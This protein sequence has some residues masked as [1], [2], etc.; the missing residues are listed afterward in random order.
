MTVTRS[1]TVTLTVTLTVL[2]GDSFT[3]VELLTATMFLRKLLG[4]KNEGN[5][6]SKNAPPP[7]M[8]AMG[9]SLQRKFAKGVQYNSKY[10][11]Y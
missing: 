9:A 11:Y 5:G 1:L 8:Q 2:A 4:S 3:V 7:G 6:D 10:Y